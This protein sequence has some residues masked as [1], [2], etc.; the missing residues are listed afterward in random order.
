MSYPK[1]LFIFAIAT[2]LFASPAWA[3]SGFAMTLRNALADTITTQ[4]GGGAKLDEFSGVRPANCAA[5]TSQVKLVEHTM[6][7][8]FAPAAS[9]AIISAT[10]P[11]NQNALM[12]GTVSWFRLYKAD[13]VTCEV[14]GDVGIAGSAAQLIVNSVSFV[15]G[16]PVVVQSF[17][18]AIGNPGI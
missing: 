6:G 1:K 8:P 11:A 12:T 3:G 7:T 17:S 2:F 14:D 5:I 15:A 13:G 4:I 10:L 16:I 18:F 9:S